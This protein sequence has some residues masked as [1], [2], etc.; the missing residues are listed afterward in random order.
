MEKRKISRRRKLLIWLAVDLAVAAV[1][2]AL[3]V[4]RPSGYRPVA[5]APNAN[6]ETVHPYLHRDLASTFYNKA[7]EQRPFDMTVLDKSLSE[8]ISDKKWESEGV[9]LSAPQVLFV[10]GRIVLMGMAD[11]E[12]AGF[13][14][15]IELAPQM[16]D[17]G[18]LDLAVEK[19]KVGAMNVTPLARMMAKKMYQEQFDTGG[20][21]MDNLAAKILAS[22]L[23][24]QPFEPVFQV[25]DRWV[26][27]NG[28]DITE[29]KLIAHFIPAK[30][31]RQQPRLAP[32]GQ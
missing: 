19:V 3:L 6:G 26:R 22:L 14:V 23:A 25:D 24:G 28:F 20:V 12:G 30:A 27:L 17:R 13:V 32:A 10:P 4:Y 11:V 16:T 15:T 18:F 31:P 9:L 1:L 8:A 2:I 21:G 29:G 7:Q 5:P